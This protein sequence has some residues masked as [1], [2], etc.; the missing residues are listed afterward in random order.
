M[1]KRLR[2]AGILVLA[3]L[4]VSLG[5]RPALAADADAPDDKKPAATSGTGDDTSAKA[6]AEP[7]PVP[8]L[9]LDDEGPS[10]RAVKKSHNGLRLS[11]PMATDDTNE[12]PF[13][14]SWV[15]WAVTGVI[16]AGA[17]GA[18]IY[19]T[20]GTRG[21][22]SPCPANITLSLGCFGAGRN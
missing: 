3:L 15:F 10:A 11:A 17:V 5:M 4:L 6:P 12:K 1:L 16:V 14:K 7:A 8:Q 22:L 2:G 21:S 18:V 19:S 20:S 13:W 9:Q